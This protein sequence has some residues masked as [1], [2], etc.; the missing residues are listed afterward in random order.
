MFS[1]EGSGRA[2]R[3][4]SMTGGKLGR[5]SGWLG[6]H[7]KQTRGTDTEEGHLLEFGPRARQQVFKTCIK[8]SDKGRRILHLPSLDGQRLREANLLSWDPV[9]HGKHYGQQS[10]DP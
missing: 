10:F 3:I 2:Q 4:L 9:N 5:G 8:L 7:R 6:R 1:E